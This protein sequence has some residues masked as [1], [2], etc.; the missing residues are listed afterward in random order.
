MKMATSWTVRLPCTRKEAEAL[1]EEIPALAVIDPQPAILTQELVP[2]DD[3]AW[4][5][6]AYFDRQPDEAIIATIQAHVPSA[7]SAIPVVEQLGDEDWVTISQ[8]AIEPVHAGRFY[9]HTA[10]NAGQPRV[11]N[12][13]FQID[14]GEAFGTGSHETTRGCLLMLDGLKANG[15]RFRD[16]ADIGTGTGILAFAALRLWG[17][18]SVTA[19]DIDPK[20]IDVTKQNAEVNAIREGN[21]VG[22]L[23]TCVCPGADHLVIQ[24][25]APYDLVIANI[26]AGPLIDLAP[27]LCAILVTGGRLILAGLLDTQAEAVIAA[28]RN[29]GMMLEKRIDEGDWP[30]LLL[31]KRPRHRAYRPARVSHPPTPKP[32][33]FGTW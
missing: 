8:R 23:A 32:G 17:R 3:N 20:S 27:S 18:A 12:I 26:L 14:T 28:Y 13:T 1:G 16:V 10:S 2:F 22:Q 30:C 15:H 5:L 21:G 25:R 7:Q 6:V 4:E 19:S 33:D 11:G 24:R 9:V 31:R 29:E